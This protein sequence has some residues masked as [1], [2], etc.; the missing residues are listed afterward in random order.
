ML[1]GT[2]AGTTAERDQSLPIGT[3]GSC[4]ENTAHTAIVKGGRVRLRIENKVQAKSL[5]TRIS[6]GANGIKAL[7]IRAVPKNVGSVHFECQSDRAYKF[8]ILTC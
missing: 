8:G 5:D 1:E 3:A 4:L 2:S 7:L 6:Q